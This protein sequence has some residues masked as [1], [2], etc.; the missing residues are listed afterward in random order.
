MSNSQAMGTPSVPS[1]IPLLNPLI[2]RLIGA[3]LPF[4]PNVLLTVRG[5]TSGLPRTFPIALLE[6]GGRRYIQS[7]FGEVDWVRNLRADPA[8]VVS[9]GERREV[10]LAV[11]VP[12]QTAGPLFRDALAPYVRWRIGAAMVGRFFHVDRDATIDDYIVEAQ[13]HP[14][15][16]L[17]AA[18]GAMAPS[19][20]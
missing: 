10:V 13:R 8:A 17:L 19:G 11:E 1:L 14:M 5:R 3:G 7:P 16:E 4:G 9:R 6:L 15:F 18:P 12:P 2:R 20:S